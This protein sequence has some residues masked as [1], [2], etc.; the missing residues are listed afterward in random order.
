MNRSHVRNPESRIR[1]SVAPGR[2]RTA[3]GLV[4]LTE[5]VDTFVIE[6][7]STITVYVLD[8]SADALSLGELCATLGYSF[9]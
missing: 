8:R 9:V 1:Q 3:N 5:E 7:R 4:V 2:A 6:L